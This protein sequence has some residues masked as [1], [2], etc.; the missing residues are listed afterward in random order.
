VGDNVVVQGED[1]VPFV[2]KIDQIKR[3]E[4]DTQVRLLWYYRP[5]EAMGGRRPFHG[6]NELFL[7]DH[8]DWCSHRCVDSKCNIHTLRQYQELPQVT[9]RDYF[10]R[11]V[12]KAKQKRF[13]PDRVPVYCLCEMPYNPDLDMVECDTCAEWYH[14][15]CLGITEQE[16]RRKETFVCPLCQKQDSRLDQR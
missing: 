16:L 6:K 4:N 2:A 15:A 13:K 11:F 14:M 10:S 5:E 12:Y 3:L 7:S 1:T 9:D 8:F